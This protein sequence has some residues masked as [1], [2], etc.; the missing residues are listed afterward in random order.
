MTSFSSCG[1]SRRAF[2][3]SKESGHAIGGGSRISRYLRPFKS[4]E[5]QPMSKSQSLRD[6]SL[7]ADPPKSM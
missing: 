2:N 7:G 3:H 4:G 6:E 5:S 1:I